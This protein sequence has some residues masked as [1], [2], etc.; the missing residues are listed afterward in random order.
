MHY[1]L[2]VL[3]NNC[4]GDKYVSPKQNRNSLC[5]TRQIKQKLFA[6]LAVSST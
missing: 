1:T 4:T 6:G 2:K 5:E 3:Y